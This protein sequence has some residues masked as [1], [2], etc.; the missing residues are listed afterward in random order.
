M[1]LGRPRAGEWICGLAGVA[2]LVSL[3]MPWYAAGGTTASAWESLVIVDWVL[4]VVGL[5]AIAVL[6]VTATSRG[7]AVPLALTSL[8]TLVAILGVL[9]ALLRVIDLP[10]PA[11]AR[12]WGL[13]LGLAGAL[14]VL[15]GGAIAMRD[16][17]REPPPP[18]I[19][20]FPAPR[21]KAPA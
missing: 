12:R 5:A 9:L 16:E 21:P 3:W 13:W 19:P 4:A 18:E 17:R 2:L 11:E 6:I 15:G 8:T 1:D 14:G 10:D 7:D 20:A